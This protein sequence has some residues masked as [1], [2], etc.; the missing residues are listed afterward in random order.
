MKDKGKDDMG[1]QQS[2]I[3]VEA[4]G[5]E[6]IEQQGATET[7]SESSP[8]SENMKE[9]ERGDGWPVYVK[10]F[11]EQVHVED[12]YRQFVKYGKVTSVKIRRDAQGLAT[13]SWFVWYSCNEDAI[14][15][16]TCIEEDG[17]RVGL[18]EKWEDRQ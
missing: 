16:V 5:N 9:E 2:G 14:R 15:A 12:I 10:G 11:D 3:S 1:A 8:E 7:S 18:A 4:K 6:W 13:C 17:L